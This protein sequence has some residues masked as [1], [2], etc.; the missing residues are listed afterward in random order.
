MR[1]EENE[2]GG[3][4]LVGRR[5]RG[6]GSRPHLYTGRTASVCVCVCVWW[7]L[8]CVARKCSWPGSLWVQPERPGTR[9]VTWEEGEECDD[10]PKAGGAERARTGG[11]ERAVCRR[12]HRS[13]VAM[14]HSRAHT[15]QPAERTHSAWHIPHLSCVPL[16]C[17]SLWP[18][19]IRLA[20]TRA[21]VDQFRPK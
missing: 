21:R 10:E 5:K 17:C 12:R 9:T 2:E 13:H 15:G 16:L 18:Y 20:R 7:S 1:E 19:Y 6:W 14:L 4:V 8:I 3:R 11:E